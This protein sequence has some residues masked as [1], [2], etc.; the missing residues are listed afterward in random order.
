MGEFGRH[1]LLTCCGIARLGR[2]GVDVP[3]FDE[4]G[5]IGVA[6]LD[7]ESRIKLLGS[8]SGPQRCGSFIVEDRNG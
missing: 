6:L 8:G 5:Q 2:A 3:L 4:L 7:V 1:E